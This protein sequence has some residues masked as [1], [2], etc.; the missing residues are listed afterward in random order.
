MSGIYLIESQCV[1]F[2]CENNQRKNGDFC[3]KK[4]GSY[5][6]SCTFALPFE[7]QGCWK[8]R[9]FY[10]RLTRMKNFQKFF[11]KRFGS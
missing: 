5:K 1:V 6:I 3:N 11:K 9:E 4:F 7:K 10:E 2:L 8:G